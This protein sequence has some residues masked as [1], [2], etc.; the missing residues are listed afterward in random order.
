VAA[1]R[2]VLVSGAPVSVVIPVRDEATRL[3]LLLADL[4]TA[5][6]DLLRE[7]WVVDGGSGDGSPRLALL[8]G[9]R[10]LHSP[11]GRGSQLQR[12]I[13]ACSSPWLLLLHAD[14]RLPAGWC[15]VVRRAMADGRRQAWAFRLAIEGS[16]SSLRLVEALVAVRSRWLSLPYGDQGLLISR[17]WLAAAG[18]IAP[19]PLMEDLELAMRLR[20]REAIGVLPASLQVS[21][22]RWQRLGVLRTAIANAR[23]RRAWQRGADPAQLAALYAAPGPETAEAPPG[24]APA[25]GAYQKAQR[26]RSGS[27]SHPWPS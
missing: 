10:L 20:R 8:A 11:A 24:G 27:S 4:A 22:R 17:S 23:L 7:V 15:S 16:D 6:A 14:A 18:G 25:Q 26:R 12:G 2:L 21:G 5:P 19:L 9:S 3:P 1:G 13:A